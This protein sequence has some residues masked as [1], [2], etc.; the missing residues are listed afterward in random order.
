MPPGSGSSKPPP[1]VY[2][3]SLPACPHF[4]DKARSRHLSGQWQS[5]PELPSPLPNWGRGPPLPLPQLSVSHMSTR[6]SPALQDSF[7]FMPQCLC[8]WSCQIQGTAEAC[9]AG[10]ARP[11]TVQGWSGS[12][13]LGADACSDVL[14][15]PWAGGTG[16]MEAFPRSWPA[17]APYLA[18]FRPGLCSLPQGSRPVG[19]G[20]RPAH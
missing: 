19:T 15:V 10:T 4:K 17:R 18:I 8:V 5:L 14:P 1:L 13:W 12:D 11:W 16:C 2:I 3:A 7:H 20:P 6:F 9:P